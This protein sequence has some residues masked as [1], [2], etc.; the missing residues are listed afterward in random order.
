MARNDPTDTGG[1]FVGRR[2]GTA[3]LRHRT[4]PEG[5]VVGRRWVHRLIAG[6]ILFFEILLCMTL[7]GP[8]PALWLWVGS[9]FDYWTGA[10]SAGIAVAFVGMMFTLMITLVI[11]K[12]LDHLWK[13]ARRAA[14]YEQRDGALEWIFVVSI[15]I[16][17]S[18]FLFWF[19]IIEGPGPSLAPRE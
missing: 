18:A 2:P 3:P 15:A 13:L 8:Q 16:C 6:F 7:W 17:F 1:L 5:T 11:A 4:P 14:G 9:Y 19:F 12:R 10:V